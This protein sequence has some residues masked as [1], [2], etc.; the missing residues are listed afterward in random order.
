MAQTPDDRF[1]ASL[2]EFL[3]WQAADL[4]GAPAAEAVAARL[5]TKARRGQ[6]STSRVVLMLVLLGLLAVALAGAVLVGGPDRLGL[7]QA[8]VPSVSPR[9]THDAEAGLP[10][11][12]GT[13]RCVEAEGTGP[14]AGTL[15]EPGPL[16]P[17]GTRPGSIAFVEQGATS[18]P[19]AI[20]DR[21]VLV[22]PDTAVRRTL[23]EVGDGLIE[24]MAWSPDGRWLAFLWWDFEGCGALYLAGAEGSAA[25][26]DLTAD[27]A[28]SVEDFAWSPDGR[29]LA[30]ASPRY[31]YGEQ[32]DAFGTPMA[33]N[34]IDIIGIDESGSVNS[35]VRLSPDDRGDMA[36]S[37][38]GRRLAV[39]SQDDRGHSV[40]F[41]TTGEAEPAVMDFAIPETAGLNLRW[42]ESMLGYLID[43]APGGRTLSVIDAGGRV[44]ETVAIGD[45]GAPV[46]SADDL[47]VALTGGDDGPRP[48]GTTSTAG[49][50]VARGHRR[51]DGP[52]A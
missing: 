27:Y 10:G 45:A 48:F 50:P 19:L 9:P 8:T 36:W 29:H 16:V 44:L 31:V 1:D 11:L 52:C 13:E 6:A 24:R 14:T 30:V 21:V 43:D 49:R 20:V 3:A 33:E 37:P 25:P 41:Y 34:R 22:D 12:S 47:T 18:D 42:T 28:A 39:T 17:R 35:M 51:S 46:F 40:K 7:L 32:S 26:V 23:A 5:S 4:A 2:H 38:D 15:P